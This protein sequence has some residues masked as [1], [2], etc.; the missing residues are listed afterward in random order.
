MEMDS[1]KTSIVFTDSRLGTEPML[2]G[3]SDY[4]IAILT[5]DPLTIS[6]KVQTSE[7]TAISGATVALNGGSGLLPSPATTDSTGA[8]SFSIPDNGKYTIT[9]SAAGYA[10]APKAQAVTVKGQDV[11]QNLTGTPVTISGKVLPYKTLGQAGITINLSGAG[12]QAL[13][14]DSSGNYIFS[15]LPNGVYTVTPVPPAHASGAL[16]F[17]PAHVK[18]SIA[19]KSPNPQNFKYQTTASCSKCH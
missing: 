9:P 5:R 1:G 11:T 15:E 12:T 19:G 17:S 13:S 4:E 7:G 14:T 3:T 18:I 16:T 8:Y 2:P 10:F 6:G